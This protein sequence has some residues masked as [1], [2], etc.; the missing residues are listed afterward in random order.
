MMTMRRSGMHRNDM[1]FD[2]SDSNHVAGE[3]TMD[4]LANKTRRLDYSPS[5]IYLASANDWI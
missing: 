3:Q 5:H 4:R 1:D 2:E